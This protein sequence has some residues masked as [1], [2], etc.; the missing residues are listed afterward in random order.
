MTGGAAAAETVTVEAFSEAAFEHAVSCSH[1][2]SDRP[3]RVSPA[4]A[5]HRRGGGSGDWKGRGV[6]QRI[7]N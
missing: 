2:S 7:A 5:R 1:C 6:F 3:R 4:L